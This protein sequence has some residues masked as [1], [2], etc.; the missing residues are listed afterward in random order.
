MGQYE[1]LSVPVE[2]GKMKG[3]FKIIRPAATP[4]APETAATAPM[5]S[6]AGDMMNKDMA[7]SSYDPD[8]DVFVGLELTEGG[9]MA[10]AKKAVDSFAKPGKAAAGS[11]AASGGTDTT[12]GKKPSDKKPAAK[13]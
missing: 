8:G 13:P 6:K 9:K 2:K 4:G 1:T 10:D 5:P 7:A 3:T 12:A 11:A